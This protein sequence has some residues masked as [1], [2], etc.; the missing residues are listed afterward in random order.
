MI[1]SIPFLEKGDLIE[2]VAPAKA[3]EPELIFKARELFESRG[4][5]VKISPNCMGSYHY[6]S[7]TI[8]ERRK[9]FQE[10]IDNPEVKAILC[11]RGGY[12]CI[13]YLDELDWSALDQHPKWVIGFSD[14]TVFHQ[15]L[16]K[17]GLPS[18]HA[19]MPLNF[20]ENTN[21]ALESLFSSLSGHPSV[22]KYPGTADNKSG[23]SEAQ[24]VGGN[25]SIIYSLIGTATQ[26]D[27]SG[28]I[29]FIEDL[30]EQLYHLDRIFYSL[31]LAGILDTITGLIIGGMTD[32]RDT[33]S[34]FGKTYQ[35]IILDHLEGRDIPVAFG[36]PAGHINDNRA[37]VFGTAVKLAVDASEVSLTYL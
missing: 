14:I 37:I 18:M 24:I 34:P 23:V 21:E 17:K 35:E 33:E 19:T 10:A 9:D 13:Q 28:K 31:K 8:D 26:P 27:Y 20:G 2:I 6:F 22:I 30:C 36:F 29:L 11:A 1:E 4:F 12:G 7:G 32:M 16:S 5:T 15:Y 25:L 3:I